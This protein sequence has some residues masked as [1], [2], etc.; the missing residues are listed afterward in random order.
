MAISAA[1]HAFKEFLLQYSSQ[2]SSQ[3]SSKATG[4]WGGRK[5]EKEK[6]RE[7]RERERERERQRGRGRGGGGVDSCGNDYHPPRKE[8]TELA[9]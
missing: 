9:N 6:E 7:R 2:V 3:Y 4:C 8:L 5:K 1:I